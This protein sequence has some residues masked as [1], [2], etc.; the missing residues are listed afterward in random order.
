MGR[1]YK[2]GEWNMEFEYIIH[3]NCD[4]RICGRLSTHESY[5]Y[6]KYCD[7]NNSTNCSSRMRDEWYNMLHQVINFISIVYL[8]SVIIKCQLKYSGKQIRCIGLNM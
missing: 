5:K 7:E 3:A 2:D 1:Y 8:M 6:V 4:S